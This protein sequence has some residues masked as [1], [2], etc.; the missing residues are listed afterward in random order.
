M[1][2]GS[3]EVG[4]AQ[5]GFVRP[6][7][8]ADQVSAGFWDAARRGVLAIQRCSS[9]QAYQHP[10][11]PICRACGGIELAFEPVS[12]DGRLWSWTVTHHNVISG[13]EATIPYTC[14]VVEL[15]E[16]PRLFVVSDLVGREQVG[17]GLVVGMPMRV[18]FPR[19]SGENPVLPQFA[20]VATTGGE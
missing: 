5:E 17:D 4:Q 9:C 20:P 15:V 14:V 8:Q 3:T 19:S 6:M 2:D 12:G 13:F 10:P 11:R 16:Q 7:P 18:T 1:S